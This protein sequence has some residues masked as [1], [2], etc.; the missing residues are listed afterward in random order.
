MRGTSSDGSAVAVPRGA[1]VAVLQGMSG[2]LL[3]R[4][5]PATGG[6]GRRK[7]PAGRADK[8]R[9]Q[10]GKVGGPQTLQI[11]RSRRLARAARPARR[12]VRPPPAGRRHTR[13]K[14]PGYAG[15]DTPPLTGSACKPPLKTCVGT[16]VQQRFQQLSD[17]VVPIRIV[18]LQSLDV[19]QFPGD[20]REIP[21]S[22][23][24]DE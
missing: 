14:R 2:L 5:L 23:S 24:S 9:A 22:W 21:S 15:L 4:V 17:F 3:C 1:G 12:A 16:S 10:G 11:I 19:L 8:R 6:G 7:R 18:A 13:I 20:G